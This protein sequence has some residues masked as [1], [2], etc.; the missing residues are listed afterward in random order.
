M[1]RGRLSILST[2]ECLSLLGEARMG[3]VA[4]SVAAMPEIFPV[5]FCLMDDDIVFRTGAGTKLYAAIKGA[6]V[7]FE[8]DEFDYDT[9]S[10][11]S[12]M[13]TGPCAEERDPTTTVEARRRL[14]DGWVPGDRDHVVRITPEKISGRR[15]GGVP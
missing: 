1:A 9:L 7:A 15:I 12:V 3:R 14:P 6:V 2:D 11:W 10:G 4:V 8:V 13:V 5:N